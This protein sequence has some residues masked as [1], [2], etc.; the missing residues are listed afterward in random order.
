[1]NGGSSGGPV[2]V[3]LTDGSWRIVGVNNRGHSLSDGYGA[4][5]ISFY[6]D[7]RFG[8]F[9]NSV[10]NYLN[11]TASAAKTGSSARTR[12]GAADFW[13]RRR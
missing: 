12:E 9:W 6:F 3:Q 4:E 5:G 2:F 13:E 11:Q 1:M 7:E 8:V 10:I